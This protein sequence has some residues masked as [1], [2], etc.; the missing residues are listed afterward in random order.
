MLMPVLGRWSVVCSIF[1]FPYARPEGLGRAFKD[2]ATWLTVAVATVV[3][4]AASFGF[5]RLTGL[6]IMLGVGI[7]TLALSLI[8]NRK[9]AG[10]TGDAYGAIIEVGEV[11][12]LILAIALLKALP[13][14]NW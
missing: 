1:A 8:L 7:V 6:A 9:F 12:S 2:H 13:S 4:L 3:A 5:L 11:T 10:L 14:W